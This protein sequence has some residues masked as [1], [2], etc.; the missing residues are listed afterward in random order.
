[1]TTMIVKSDKGILAFVHI[2]YTLY[3]FLI[4]NLENPTRLNGS[5]IM[6]K[7]YKGMKNIFF[8]PEM[9]YVLSCVL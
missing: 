2:L 5:L 7:E 3:Y 9:A 4:Y 1:M 8:V 6:Y